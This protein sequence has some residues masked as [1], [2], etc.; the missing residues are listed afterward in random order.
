MKILEG[1]K[2]SSYRWQACESDPSV[3]QNYGIALEGGQ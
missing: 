3:G 1:G 2:S